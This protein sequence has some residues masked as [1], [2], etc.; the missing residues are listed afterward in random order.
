MASEKATLAKNSANKFLWISSVY[1]VKIRD[2]IFILFF[3]LILNQFLANDLQ[4]KVFGY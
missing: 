3:S 4:S 1:N 2:I